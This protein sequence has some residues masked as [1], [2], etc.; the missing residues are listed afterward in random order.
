MIIT[1]EDMK[2][3]LNVTT[4]DDDALITAKIEAAQ[5]HIE[6]LLPAGSLDNMAGNP[7]VCEAVRQLAAHFY[8]NREAVLVGVNAQE[9]P[10]GVYQLLLP[11][12]DWSF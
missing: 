6:A 1:L 11:H 10:M 8:E 4:N 2:A 3:H 9:L 7:D 5:A 12:R